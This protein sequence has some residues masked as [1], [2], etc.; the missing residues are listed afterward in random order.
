MVVRCGICLC[1]G[2]RRGVDSSPRGG[3]AGFDSGVRGDSTVKLHEGHKRPKR[4]VTNVV[5]T[6]DSQ[7]QGP[8]ATYCFLGRK[9][10]VGGGGAY[11]LG[12]LQRLL[13]LLQGGVRGGPVAVVYVQ[14]RRPGRRRAHPI[15]PHPTNSQTSPTESRSGLDTDAVELTDKKLISQLIPVKQI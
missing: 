2:E 11:P 13:V 10:G 14:I 7:E 12:V 9:R 5:N 6:Q 4:G 15:Q 3:G 1:G 8:C